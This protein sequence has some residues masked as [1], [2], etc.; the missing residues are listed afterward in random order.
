MSEAVAGSIAARTAGNP[1]FVSELT[2]LLRSERALNEQAVKAAPV[3]AGVRDVIRRRIDR[4]P[5]QTTTV[6]TVAA[7]I[8]RRFGLDLLERVTMLPGDELLD[9]VESAVATGLV[10]ED[11]QVLGR[12]GF[13]HDLVRETLQAAVGGTRRA[14]VHYRVAQALLDQAGGGDPALPFEL[15]HHPV[16]AVPLVP[17]EEVVGHVVAAADAAVTRHAFDQA[18]VELRQALA[19]IDLIP[20]PARP[21]HELA[22]RVRLARVLTLT[23]GHASPEE[24]EHARRAAELAQI[25]RMEAEN[26]PEATHALW[27]AALSVGMAGDLVTPMTIG[28]QLVALGDEQGD[29][30]A[31]CMGHALLGGFAWHGAD[32]ATAA[33]HLGLVVEA[34]DS[35]ELDPRLF[36]DRTRGVW[37]RATHALVAWL[38]GDDDEAGA[39]SDDALRRASAPD[40]DFAR[41]YALCFAAWLGVFRGDRTAARRQA[42]AG[43]EQADALGFGQLRVLC[44]VLRAAS[45]VDPAARFDELGGATADWEATGARL[46]RGFF[47]ALQAQALLDLHRPADAAALLTAALDS[48]ATSGERFYEPEIH[49]LLGLAALQQERPDLAAEHLERA[50]AL[51]TA[52]GLVSLA[53]R[54]ATSIEEVRARR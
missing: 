40:Q 26:R 47:S 34:V 2:R 54:A 3:P 31:A 10:T 41:L 5:P 11:D 7:I 13:T 1:L 51:A 35:G 19:L 42:E 27:G 53:R 23:R 36:H 24:R 49:R 8:G 22:V 45:L 32:L 21:D 20:G 38:A 14:R 4:L 29:R 44:R 17:A 28:R 48:T 43:I 33:H 50:A 46:Y 18:E 30:A 12:F 16:H 15:A 9:R 25:V 37:S 52:L 6:L 39:L